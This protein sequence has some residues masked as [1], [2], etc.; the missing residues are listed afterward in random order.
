MEAMIRLAADLVIQVASNK[1]DR[2]VEMTVISGVCYDGPDTRTRDAYSMTPSTAR[3][4]SS[5]LLGGA[6]EV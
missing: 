3:M 4:L 5:A 6:Q 1:Q 2:R